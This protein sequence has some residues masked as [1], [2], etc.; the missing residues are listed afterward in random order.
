MRYS[1]T[2]SFNEKKFKK[3]NEKVLFCF[4]KGGCEFFNAIAFLQRF[5]LLKFVRVIVAW[6]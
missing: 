2:S 1:V 6:A 3:F 5:L 4:L